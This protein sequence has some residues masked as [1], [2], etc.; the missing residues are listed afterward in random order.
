MAKW[1]NM[2]AIVWLLKSRK[3][4]TAEQ[5]SE[6]LE[7][8]IR[9]VYRYIDSLC[10]SGVPIVAEPGHDGGYHLPESFR[11]APLFFEP[12]ELKSLFHAAS[13][14]K[15]A[16]Y[17]YERDLMKALDKIQHQLSEEQKDFLQRHTSGFEVLAMKND[18]S[19]ALLLQQLEQAVA[20]SQT[21]DMLYEKGPG[22]EPNERRIDP[23]GLFYRDKF[24]YVV[25]FCHLRNG[26]RTFRVDRILDLS[27]SG[28]FFERPADFSIQDY[29]DQQWGY[30][31]E[32]DEP[33]I[34]VHI[35]GEPEVIDY[36]C[37]YFNHCLVENKEGEARFKI[38]VER[39]ENYLPGFL[40]S[41]GTSIQVLEPAKLR[42]AMAKVARKLEK[43]YETDELP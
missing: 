2:L 29:I 32:A 43:Y 33:T 34:A 31:W 15:G 19:I 24:W 3:S 6:R 21:F 41:F 20:E 13:F 10:A 37:Q 22:E 27:A 39:V 17:P 40:V 30:Q 38:N 28:L 26:L 7:I 25:A 14:A 11:E 36:L 8:S 1:E 5:I 18:P 35:K 4:M 9:T 12:N 16:G 23:Y 42:A